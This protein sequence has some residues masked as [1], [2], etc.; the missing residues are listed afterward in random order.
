MFALCH[1]ICKWKIV[2]QEKDGVGG[3]EMNEWMKVTILTDESI[4]VGG[5][6]PVQATCSSS[7]LLWVFGQSPQAVSTFSL[8]RHEFIPQHHVFYANV[9]PHL[10]RFKV[11]L[12]V[13]KFWW[14][15]WGLIFFTS[16]QNSEIQNKKHQHQW[17]LG[18]AGRCR[19]PLEIQKIFTKL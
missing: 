16:G 5:A 11:S 4:P 8:V 13:I 18:R 2:L 6:P 12:H 7:P 10:C 3:F 14:W 15:T 9:W 17:Y 19:T 1:I